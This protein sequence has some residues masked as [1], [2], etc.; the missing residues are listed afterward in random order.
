M[1]R[2]N[3]PVNQ[4]FLRRS[5][6]LSLST[7]LILAPLPAMAAD[8]P[9][10]AGSAAS[11]INQS[12]GWQPKADE[13]DVKVDLGKLATNNSD[14]KIKLSTIKFSGQTL[15]TD[16]E[17]EAQIQDL[18]KPEVT[19]ADLQAM[20][21]RITDLYHKGGYITAIAYLPAQNIVDGVVTIG[22]LEGHYDQKSYENTSELVTGRADGLT[23]LAKKGR[24]IRLQD[25]DRTVLILND[26]PGVR[27]HVYISPGSETGTAHTTFKLTRTERSGGF[28]YVDN[29]G[30]RYTG[31]ER[32]GGLYHWD[33][34]GHVG[35]QLQIGY[36]RSFRGDDLG[37]Y[38]I[39]YELP[40]SNYGTF[41]GIEF[42]RTNYELGE[43]YRRINAYGTSSTWRIYSRTPWKRTQNNNLYFHFSYAHSNLTDRIDIFRTDAEKH[44]D[45]IRFGLDGD[46]RNSHS[47]STYKL[48]HTIGHIGMDTDYSRNQDKY[49]T[50]GCYQKTTLDAYHIER[51]ND[52]WNLHASLTAQIGW[53]NLDSSEKF[54]IGGYNA[55]RAYPQGE[56]GGD[57]GI[58]GSLEFRYRTGNPHIQLAG[59]YDFG[60]V[61]CQHE[62]LPTD[63][64]NSR[65]LAGIGLGILWSSNGNSFARLDYAIPLTN[66][67][68]ENEGKD[69]GSRWWFQYI[70]KI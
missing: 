34:V 28:L 66:H 6:M 42:S 55:V 53:K 56:T 18:R 43:N 45:A 13:A 47:A 25:L 30:N 46:Y 58:L 32:I 16:A 41:G 31:R 64:S 17:L 19:F 51:L 38:D 10:S 12:R 9:V 11:G 52:R 61:R 8:L 40:V 37:N 59:F 50:E 62:A 57:S 35:D 29:Y 39:R 63:T 14:M 36:L 1:E 24:I 70:Q 26:I 33:N 68:S 3:I 48:M 5:I 44:G 23:H 69:I 2:K 27:A 21:Q 67:H 22:I 20:A 7:S 54:Y 49:H 65:T 4:N 15:Y 60:Y